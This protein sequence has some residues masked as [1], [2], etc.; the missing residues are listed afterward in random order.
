MSPGNELID[1]K[2]LDEIKKIFTKSD[3]VLFA[4]G[5]DKRRKNI[6]RVR[7]FEKKLS[8]K[9]NSKYVQCV[10]SGTAAIKIALK[11][12]GAETWR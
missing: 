12:L 9:F 11:A 3:G 10:S 7:N 2:E 4:H 6:F 1:K 5:F 8:K